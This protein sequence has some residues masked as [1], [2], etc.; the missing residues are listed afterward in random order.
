MRSHY[1][2]PMM[3]RDVIRL[4][5]VTISLVALYNNWFLTVEDYTEETQEI[6]DAQLPYKRC[7]SRMF[8][9]IYSSAVTLGGW[10]ITLCPVK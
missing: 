2:G 4:P 6:S 7:E 10:A 1:A 5:P 9:K 8:V 3:S